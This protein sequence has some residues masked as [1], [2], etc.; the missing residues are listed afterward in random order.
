MDDNLY[1]KFLRDKYA[2]LREHKILLSF[3]LV[4]TIIFSV[5]LISA[6][7][8]IVITVP[9]SIN[10]DIETFTTVNFTINNTQ[11]TQNITNVTIRLPPEFTTNNF[12]ATSNGSTPNVAGIT[13]IA[14]FSYA[15]NNLT[16]VNVTSSLINSSANRSFWIDI[17]QSMPGT[18]NITINITYTNLSIDYYN[19]TIT[20]NDTTIPALT[21]NLQNNSNL[22]GAADEFNVTIIDYA[23]NFSG[24][25]A[26]LKNSTGY[27]NLS[28]SVIAS[29][30]FTNWTNLSRFNSTRYSNNITSDNFADGPYYLYVNATD[31]ATN[32]GTAPRINITID[33]T[34]PS[35]TINLQNNSNLTGA[36][37]YFNAT[38]I[39]DNKNLTGVFAA[40]KNSTGYYNLSGSRI[41]GDFTNW[42]NL[43]G[44]NA[45]RYSNNITSDNF[46]DGYYLLYVNASDYLL[47]NGTAPTINITIDNTNPLITINLKNNSNLTGVAAGFSVAVVENNTNLT[48]VF[49]AIKNSTGYYNLSGSR[50]LGDFTNWTNLPN[51]NLSRY[52]GT[53][54]NNISSNNLA[55][56]SYLLYVNASDY[57]SNNGTAPIINI[58]IDNTAP[59]ASL[60]FPDNAT[61][62]TTATHIF[63]CN[64]SDASE[65]A[66]I[67]FY[68]YDSSNS[69]FV[70]ISA[71]NASGAFNHSNFS[72]TIPYIG[73]FLWNCRANDTLNNTG[74]AGSNRT[75]TINAVPAAAASS[76]GGGGGTAPGITSDIGALTLSSTNE[77]KI[78]DT[79]KFTVESINHSIRVIGLT[80]KTASIQIKSDFMMK[81]LTLGAPA[82]EVDVDN[83]GVAEI[84]LKLENISLSSSKA[85]ITISPL[86][87]IAPAEQQPPAQPEEN[88]TEK[89]AEPEKPPA[90]PSA[91]THEEEGN[92]FLIVIIAGIILALFAIV[93]V[94][95]YTI[96]RQQPEYIIEQQTEQIR[97][98]YI[99]EIRQLGKDYLS[100][101]QK[102]RQQPQQLEKI[103]QQA[104][105]RQQQIKQNFVQQL[106]QLRQRYNQQQLKGEIE[107]R[108]GLLR[109]QYINE[110][111]QLGQKYMQLQQQFKQQPQQMQQIQ[112]QF[113]E[114]QQ[115]AKQR[116]VQQ[117]QRLR[118]EYQE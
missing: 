18:Y 25:F 38:V 116:F 81:T 94:A 70:N 32:N 3:I 76:G 28:G 103:Q 37:D 99:S 48:G 6:A 1:S 21:I 66:N 20:V 89:P 109:E 57:F 86:L 100:A 27:Y 50:I 117:L 63:S 82:E 14:N 39:D 74:W 73:T 29:G 112:K 34:N 108:A 23:I 45:T 111:R 77:M 80:A 31:N 62:T 102:F 55:D 65:V 67:T 15:G 98:Q 9:I 83:D 91:P 61:S 19:Q 35:I 26:A 118:Q 8:F 113:I 104:K 44:F 93:F 79:V 101:S 56:G 53:Y 46:A 85:I 90:A 47:N 87:G 54:T 88:A 7:S 49:A 95:F 51:F 13:G 17:N 30:D 43:P 11:L 60:I 84:S 69:S 52:S 114:R 16:W 12:N 40:L 92:I 72:Y 68:L 110:T 33:N 107:K 71:N 10:E 2:A 22:T 41:L 42:T 64:A 105:E 5:C 106:Q 115:Q 59:N 96:R 58:T 97:Q 75:I 78:G 4:A 24:V 36:A